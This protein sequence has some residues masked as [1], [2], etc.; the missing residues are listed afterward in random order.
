MNCPVCN[1]DSKVLD[2]NRTRRRRECLHCRYRWTTVEVTT[3]RYKL[4][5]KL[6]EIVT[7]LQA[8]API[9]EPDYSPITSLA[10]L[11]EQL[12]NELIRDFDQYRHKLADIQVQAKA[13]ELNDGLSGAVIYFLLSADKEIVYVGLSREHKKRMWRHRLE[14][15]WSY[16]WAFTVPSERLEYI[17]EYYIA[18]FCPRL[19]GHSTAVGRQPG[20]FAELGFSDAQKLGYVPEDL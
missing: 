2:S 15:A 8:D 18:L 13:Y 6:E 5:V 1:Q 3:Q 20:Q 14:K 7:Q 4:L 19:N 11:T 16:W 17:E 9:R 10:F 12:E